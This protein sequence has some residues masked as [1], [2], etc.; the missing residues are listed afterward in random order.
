MNVD[1][2]QD[3]GSVDDDKRLV[4][5]GGA[6]SWLVPWHGKTARLTVES[7]LIGRTISI[8]VDGVL[9]SRSDRSTLEK[10]WVESL[11][12]GEGP[13]V[14]VVQIQ[15]QKYV[16]RTLVFVNA[17]DVENG[18]TLASWR[19]HRPVALDGFEQAFSGRFWGP[20]G[21]LLTGLVV[22]LP[23]LAEFSR[24][25]EPVWA[26]GA[27]AAFIVGAAWLLA[28]TRLISWLKTKRSWPNPLRRLMVP[29]VILGVPILVVAL[30]SALSHIR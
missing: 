11:L 14:L 16:T 23:F 20:W 21:A 13:P 25:R 2:R 22:V 3:L 10:P 1:D 27:I 9:V 6:D 29:S 17:V 4:S 26:V 30:A 12:P 15:L 7:P 24:T 19:T 8:L 28:A 18:V 5:G